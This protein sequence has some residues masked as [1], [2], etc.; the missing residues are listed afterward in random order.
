[1]TP[2]TTVVAATT[3]A[4]FAVVV[5]ATEGVRGLVPLRDG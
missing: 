5:R 2:R 1:L 4:T 3:V